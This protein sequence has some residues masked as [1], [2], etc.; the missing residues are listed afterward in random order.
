M[1]FGANATE[2]EIDDAVATARSALPQW[3][4]CLPVE[5]AQM[6]MAFADALEAHAE[7]TSELVTRENGMPISTSL[8]I[9]GHAPAAMLRYYADMITTTEVEETR[10]G[11]AGQIVVRR[12]AVGA[13]AAIV[14]WNHP[15][16]LAM[17]KLA[18]AL[19]AG[20]TVVLKLAPETALDAVVFGQAALDA[21]LP[22]GVI[23]V[24]AGCTLAG[25]YLVAHPGVD[26]VAFTGSTASGRSIG[27]VCGRLVRPVTLE[28]GGKSAAIILEDA[29]LAATTDGL[30]TAALS[31]NRQTCWVCARI[32][33]PRAR[34][35]E[36]VD[37]IAAMADGLNVGDPLDVTTDIGPLVSARQ[38]ERVLSFIDM[39]RQ[40]AAKLVAGGGIP[41][42]QPRGWFVSP[43]VFADVDNSDRIAR[44]EIFGPVLVVIPYEAV[45]IAN[46]SQY[47]LGG[48]VWSADFDRA[49]EIARALETGTVGING[50]AGDVNA[51][52]GGVKA[53]GLG[54]E[55]GPEGLGTYLTTKSI[56]KLSA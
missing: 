26:H 56:H 54:R 40:S 18:P 47:G 2:S 22:S 13:V 8:A 48:S 39:G 3:R 4:A 33:A 37:A 50:Y 35:A 10:E 9:E 23:N 11:S 24:V 19:A 1:G 31:N 12:K 20:C 28:L 6:L 21:G 7:P 45:A 44:E 36:V 53:S 51:P 46:D 30:H 25:Q 42:D 5:R 29:D 32:L 34:Y 41:K 38:R 15:Q 52:F 17:M 16:T 55:L 14:P 49:I 27:E 43:T